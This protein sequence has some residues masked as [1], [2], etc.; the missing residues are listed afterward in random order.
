MLLHRWRGWQSE[1]WGI[2]N[3]RCELAIFNKNSMNVSCMPFVVYKSFFRD[4][5]PFRVSIK[6]FNPLDLTLNRI[7]PHFE[8]FDEWISWLTS[9][10]QNK[11]RLFASQYTFVDLYTSVTSLCEQWN[12]EQLWNPNQEN[13]KT[14][15]YGSSDP[16]KTV[17]LF[18]NNP[19]N[20]HL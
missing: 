11:L 16:T 7:C 9:S 3:L 20:H 8:S 1:V 13:S 18:T 6:R 15:M 19:R 5:Q 12:N 2:T 17:V 10:L 14:H 4:Y